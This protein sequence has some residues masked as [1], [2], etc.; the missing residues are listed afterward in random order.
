M[1]R[2]P[3][4]H[5]DARAHAASRPHGS[6]EPSTIA[7]H[8]WLM[9]V[10]VVVACRWL[11]SPI[12]PTYDDAFITYRY[13]Q[14]LADGRGLVFNPG[15]P[16]EP[17][18]GTT[19]PLYALL[20]AGL[21]RLGAD[22]VTASLL[23][24]AL[25]D[26]ITA[27]CLPRLF[28]RARAASI[29]ALLAFAVLPPLVRIGAGGMESPLFLACGVGAAVAAASDRRVLAGTLAAATCLVRPE[30]V[31]LCA[32]MFVSQCRGP[33]ERRTRDLVRFT[34]PIV[35]VGAVA[36]AWL[37]H[38]YGTPIPQSVTAKSTMRQGDWLQ[39]SIV[40]W[41]TILSQ[42]FWPNA[43]LLPFLP[44]V[45]FG[46]WRAL[47]GGGPLR[48][49]SL[50]ALAITGSYLA[51]RPHTWGWYF[52]VP[53]AAWALWCGGG[54]GELVARLAPRVS[55]RVREFV[56]RGIVPAACTAIVAAAWYAGRAYPT[57]VRERVY[58]P[59]ARWA[60]STSAR[61]P[62]SRILASDI[63]AIGWHWRG[64]VLDSEG[65]VWPAAL[66]YGSPM[67]IVEHEKPEYLMLVAER[68]RVRQFRAREDLR[69]A[70]E[71]IL[72]FS[73]GGRTS[74]DPTPEECEIYWTQDYL[75]F[76]RRDAR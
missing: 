48:V 59:M 21:A 3:S 67:A 66:T 12:F 41:K 27:A 22:L 24:N 13:A 61:E 20:L 6:A 46:A 32:V 47:K 57:P 5:A 34:V 14:N 50:W 44:L 33:R 72:R 25:L 15:E 1:T 70:Y 71:P 37:V 35:V 64:T 16:W 62:G 10:L 54:A 18:L 4:L 65:L 49:V 53:L 40:R 75:I 26:A 60:E 76:R 28:G 73:A 9:L 30:G 31:L 69:A 42:A 51:A 68:F 38:V 55:S 63:G 43:F 23:V 29:G 2:M 17:V 8:E 11:A 58:E 19:T 74:L 39:E 56:S 36:I 52:Y 7:R 45:A